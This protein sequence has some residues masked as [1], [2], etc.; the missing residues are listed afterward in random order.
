MGLNYH[1]EGM[2]AVAP[3]VELAKKMDYQKRLPRIYVATGTYNMFITEDI[4][5]GIEDLNKAKTL[6]EETGDFLS[7]WFACYFLGFAHFLDC[8]F[9]KSSINYKMSLDL[10]KMADNVSGICFARSSDAAHTCTFTGKIEIAYKESKESLD[11]AHQSGDIYIQQMAY[12]C[13][14]ACCFFKGSFDEAETNLSEA[15]RLNSKFGQ[16]SW[17]LW[18]YF[19]LGELYFNIGNLEKAQHSYMNA[20][21]IF[22]STKLWPSWVNLMNLKLVRTKLLVN[23]EN[24]QLESI[25]EYA[26]KNKLKLCDG[27]IQNHICGIL[28]NINSQ[29]FSDAEKW[30]NSAIESSKKYGETFWLA[31]DYAL[32]AELLKRKDDHLGAKLKLSKAIEIYKKCGAVGWVEKYE[33][34]LAALS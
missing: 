11:L 18:A 6:S 9:E 12:A 19:W 1:Y 8:N 30:I 33:K 27:L 20:N 29:Y 15:I 2:Q 26:K 16:L 10:S 21:Y 28:M 34:E 4:V 17:G 3:I 23:K 22:E 14:G 5:K 25:L 32:Y 24:I 7:L 13:F 31:Q